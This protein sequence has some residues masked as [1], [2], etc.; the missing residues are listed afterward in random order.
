M[1]LTAENAKDAEKFDMI[2]RIDTDNKCEF[3]RDRIH[4][5]RS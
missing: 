2:N 1:I 3:G 4:Q 5:S